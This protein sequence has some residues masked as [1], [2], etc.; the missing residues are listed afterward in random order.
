MF[1]EL[2]CFE[3]LEIISSL[4]QTNRMGLQAYEVREI[5]TNVEPENIKTCGRTH[6]R[7]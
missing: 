2:T 7:Q 3:T 1:S 4:K 6:V 5:R